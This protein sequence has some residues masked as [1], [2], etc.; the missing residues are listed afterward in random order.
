VIN[1]R[2]ELLGASL[3]LLSVAALAQK[4][5][6]SKDDASQAPLAY[7]GLL[8]LTRLLHARKLSTVEVVQAQLARIAAIDPELHSY[9]RITADLALAQARM[10]EKAILAGE[11]EGPLHGAP[12]GI[13]DVIWTRDAITAAGSAQ[14]ANY[15]PG[16]NAAC[17]DR[18]FAA[19]AILLGKLTTTEFAGATYDPSVP[20]PVNPWNPSLW[21]GASSSGP[22]VGVAAGLCYGALGTDTGGSVR[23]PSALDG[24]VGF[25][26]TWSRISTRGIFQSVPSMDHIGPMARNV[27]DV[28]AIYQAIAGADAKDPRTSNRPVEHYSL[29]RKGD[30][31]GVRIGLDPRFGL[32]DADDATRKLI[33]SALA[34]LKHLGGRIL[35]VNFPDRAALFESVLTIAARE[36]ITYRPADAV[37]VPDQ[38]QYQ[39][40]VDWRAR[41]TRDV[42]ALFDHIDILITPVVPRA[43]MHA[44]GME[45]LEADTSLFEETLRYVVPFDL[46]GSPA[47]V[48]P[49]GSNTEGG[50]LAVQLVAQRFRENILL[51]VG[52]A[53]EQATTWHR[54]HPPR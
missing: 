22:G 26:P 7:L 48:L 13:K 29:R 45:R 53:F 8:E 21:A 36:G 9:I 3:G 52:Y 33:E 54:R 35:T 1:N 17:V 10:A 11:I 37:P 15:L 4:P 42:S 47:L 30:L 46:T 51:Q 38:A 2:R 6:T 44:A 25:K 49:A 20:V 32:H 39:K 14:Y 12:M 40:A 31:K 19:G 5:A 18:L 34:T 27:E 16:T 50:P 43:V 23:F 24:I 41:L 28:S